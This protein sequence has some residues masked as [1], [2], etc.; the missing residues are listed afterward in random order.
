MELPPVRYKPIGESFEEVGKQ[1]RDNMPHIRVGYENPPPI[2][3]QPQQNPYPQQQPIPKSYP[4]PVQQPQRPP[5]P[6]PQ[7]P[8]QQPYQQ[9]PQDPFF[10]PQEQNTIRKAM[11]WALVITVLA[12]VGY[13][14]Y[15]VFF[16]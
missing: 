7:Y 3:Q 8:Y 13:A 4:Q 9:Q 11:K 1:I 2:Q 14:V 6:P 15:R 12:V 10:N 5:Q 16:G